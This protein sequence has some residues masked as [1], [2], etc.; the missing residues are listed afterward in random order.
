M[1]PLF[2]RLL[3]FA[4]LALPISVLADNAP[5]NCEPDVYKTIAR[6]LRTSPLNLGTETESGNVVASALQALAL[7][8]APADCGCGL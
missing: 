3:T 2:V 6:D 8:G 5:Q 4:F 7:Q 1:N